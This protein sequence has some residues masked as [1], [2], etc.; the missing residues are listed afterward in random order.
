MKRLRKILFII[1]LLTVA[2]YLYVNCFF[3]IEEGEFGLVRSEQ[4][5]DIIRV[6]DSGYQII[7]EGIFPGEISLMTFRKRE[8]RLFD[9][10]IPIPSLEMTRSNFYA[11]TIPVSIQY[12]ISPERITLVTEEWGDNRHY[13][14][15]LLERFMTGYFVREFTPYFSPVY[16][17]LELERDMDRIIQSVS[18]SLIAQGRAIGIEITAFRL[19]GAVRLPDA[20]TFSD[21]LQYLRELMEVEKNNKKELIILRSKLERDEIYNKQF[22]KKLEEI[23]KL[24]K[25]N[26]DLLKYM[27]IEKMADKVKV[28]ITPEQSGM[29]FGL[30]FGSAEKEKRTGD[31]DNLR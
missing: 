25:G 1:I 18:E 15:H 7:P 3:I 16:R 24:I 28:I 2:G 11:I 29:P 22:Y 14:P 5:G 17:R 8:S 19:S 21:G 6:L 26:P 4:T 20:G 12:A 13:I 10:S 27:Y 23:S 31:I 30:D 9:L